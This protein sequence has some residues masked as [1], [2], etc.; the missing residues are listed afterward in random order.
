MFE[1]L[2]TGL[3][4]VATTDPG[5][6]QAAEL[7]DKLA[8]AQVSTIPVNLIFGMIQHGYVKR[9]SKRKIIFS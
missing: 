3:D 6:K 4:A 2:L 1:G 8:C 5:E 7:V 9:H